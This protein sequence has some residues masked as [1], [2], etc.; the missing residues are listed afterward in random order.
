MKEKI[1]TDME[2][3]ERL[4]KLGLDT[5]TADMYRWEHK[6]EWYVSPLAEGGYNVGSNNDKLCWSFTALFALL[7]VIDRDEPM[8]KHL[9]T[10]GRHEAGNYRICYNNQ[11]AHPFMAY[12]ETMVDAAVGIIVKMIKAGWIFESTKHKEE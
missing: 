6:G 4:I 9:N 5:N 3:S 2:Q 8:L 1:C 7:P 10:V 11:T 12:G